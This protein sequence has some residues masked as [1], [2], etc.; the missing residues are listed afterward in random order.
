VQ[1]GRAYTGT[2]LALPGAAAAA[3]EDAQRFIALDD[4]SSTQN[5]DPVVFPTPELSFANSMRVGQTVTNVTGVL[6]Y[7]FSRWKVIPSSPADVVFS[8][9]ANPRPTTPPSAPAGSLR[10]V[11]MNVLN[12]F[13]NYA[14][15]DNRGANNAA[16]FERQR[17]KT[18]AAILAMS[19]A[20]AGL[21][22]LQNNGNGAGSA[23]ADLA[24]AANAAATAAGSAARWSALAMEP[25]VVGGDAIAVKYIYQPALV[26]PAGGCFVMNSSVDARFIDTRSRPAL[27]QV[28]RELATNATF[29]TV[30]NHLKSKGSAC[31]PDDPDAGDGQVCGIGGDSASCCAVAV[32]WQRPGQAGLHAG[33]ALSLLPGSG[34]S[35]PCSGAT[36]RLE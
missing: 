20:L 6:T 26:A 9:A 16:E 13:N 11:A 19:P 35:G 28:W 1:G 15:A 4:A 34:L 5:P 21:M 12:Y 14:A 24:A 7:S 2:H 36:W 25:Q 23:V 29:T 22:E 10:V 27:I 8:A 31:T 3:A 17:V 33:H 18:A 32:V 30:L